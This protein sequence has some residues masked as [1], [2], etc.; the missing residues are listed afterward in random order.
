MEHFTRVSFEAI[1]TVSNERL[2]LINTCEDSSVLIR[3]A[4]FE[5][6]SCE[7]YLKRSQYQSHSPMK[8]ALIK[9]PLIKLCEILNE[10]QNVFL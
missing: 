4:L 5:S 10:Y 2:S 1:Q 9:L 6:A 3:G 7:I 8:A